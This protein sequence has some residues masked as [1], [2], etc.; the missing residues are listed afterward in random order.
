MASMESTAYPRFRRLIPAREL[1]AFFTPDAEEIRWAKET[2]DTDEHLLALMVGLKCAQR[3]SRFPRRA[4]IPPVVVEHVRNCLELPT[5]VEARY[6]SD[7]T[8]R[9]HRRWIRTRIELRYQPAQARELAGGRSA[10]RRW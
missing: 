3:L 1:H 5:Q 7:R 8:E 9:Q 6:A 4:E 10:G 2:C